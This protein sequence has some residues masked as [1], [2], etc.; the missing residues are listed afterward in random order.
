MFPLTMNG[1]TNNG[2]LSGESEHIPNKPR[3]LGCFSVC[4]TEHSVKKLFFSAS[5]SIPRNK[6]LNNKKAR[7]YEAT[8]ITKKQIK[9]QVQQSKGA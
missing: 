3:T 2:V 4:I 6:I 7:C 5:D 8:L 9:V 1:R